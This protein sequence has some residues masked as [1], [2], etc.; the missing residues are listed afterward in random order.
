MGY[1]DKKHLTLVLDPGVS[2]QLVIYY[3]YWMRDW[4]GRGLAVEGTA[5]NEYQSRVTY[6]VTV[7]F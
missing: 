2:C 3:G 1:G 5:N 6:Q 7:T 4:G